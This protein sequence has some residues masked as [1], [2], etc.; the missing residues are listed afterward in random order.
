MIDI[1]P[2]EEW[3]RRVFGE[4]NF[5]IEVRGGE[6]CIDAWNPEGN[7]IGMISEK[8]PVITIYKEKPS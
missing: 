6:I 7:C 2:Y 8:K 4:G 3:A 1:E 5:T